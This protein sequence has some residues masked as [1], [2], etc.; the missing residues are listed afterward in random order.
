MN[1]DESGSLCMFVF[2]LWIFESALSATSYRYR[3]CNRERNF[4]YALLCNKVKQTRRLASPNRP[5]ASI[6]PPPTPSALLPPPRKA[7]TGLER[8]LKANIN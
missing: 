7:I 4:A 2:E 1:N 5:R 3:V 6:S 8:Q